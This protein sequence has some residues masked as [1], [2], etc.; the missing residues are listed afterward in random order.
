MAFPAMSAFR[1]QVQLLGLLEVSHR[2][3]DNR[4]SIPEN[5]FPRHL[6]IFNFLSQLNIG[7]QRPCPTGRWITIILYQIISTANAHMNI[8][9]NCLWKSAVSLRSRWKWIINLRILLILAQLV[10]TTVRTKRFGAPTLN[11]SRARTIMHS[12]THPPMGQIVH[13]L[14]AI[15][16]RLCTGS[17]VP[18]LWALS[19]QRPSP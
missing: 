17:Q 1:L 8:S 3:L 16:L 6:L 2:Y 13:F 14:H 11:R 7:G 10:F 15:R 12:R 19:L 9:L 18:R 5:L 4:V